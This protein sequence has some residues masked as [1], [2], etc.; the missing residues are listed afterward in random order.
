MREVLYLTDLKLLFALMLAAL[1]AS[2]LAP[3]PVFTG[4][5]R[6]QIPEPRC[7]CSGCNQP[8]GSGHDSECPYADKGS[9]GGSDKKSSG[10][11]LIG[12]PILV[13]PVGVVAGAFAGVVWW[14]REMA[15]RYPGQSFFSSYHQFCTMEDDPTWASGAFSFGMHVGAVPWLALYLVT[16][17]IRAGV[18][19][20]AR[21]FRRPAK[22]PKP[23]PPHPD[24]AVHELIARNYASL[25]DLTEQELGKAQGDV[26]ASQLRRTRLLDDHIAANPEL[27]E[28]RE[29]EGLEAARARAEK[30]LDA[31][32]KARAE[33][34]KLADELTRGIH[35]K[36][37]AIRAEIDKLNPLSFLDSRL[38]DTEDRLDKALAEPGLSQG[39]RASLTRERQVTRLLQKGKTA[40]D[41]GANLKE[42][43]DSYENARDRD[44]DASEWI[45]ERGA[46]ESVWRLQLK[47]LSLP[48]GKAAGKVVGSLQTALDIAYTAAVAVKLGRQIDTDVATLDRLR[49][50]RVF[51]DAM[52]DDWEQA[53]RAVRSA[54]AT[55]NTVAR[56]RDRYRQLGKESQTR[57][58]ALR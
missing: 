40:Y 30:R 37:D 5:A 38:Q 7:V 29:R 57:A 42:L 17:P 50:A 41:I 12:A 10:R 46:R 45:Q 49:T 22:P 52:A 20:L 3:L 48:L 51:Q 11:G 23:K 54:E 16:G 28:I 25:G 39:V 13:A 4:V 33:K 35:E 32:A 1:L 21:W 44:L 36:D 53:N 31:W 15:G 6:A 55:R 2:A 58:D 9:S 43:K 56:R 18:V 26:D 19:G 24:I 14:Y 27:Q 34:R 8:C 47:L